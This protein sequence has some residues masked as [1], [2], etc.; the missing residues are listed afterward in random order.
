MIIRN[1]LLTNGS[2]SMANMTFVSIQDGAVIAKGKIVNMT[3]PNTASQQATRGIFTFLVAQ[4]RAM[5]G[6]LNLIN[7]PSSARR[8]PFNQFMANNIGNLKEQLGDGSDNELNRAVLTLK[9]QLGDSEDL[10]NVVVTP[11]ATTQPVFVNGVVDVSVEWEYDSFNPNVLGTDG[12][13]VILYN[14]EGEYYS[15]EDGVATMSQ[16]SAFVTIRRPAKGW[17]FYYFIWQRG[18]D[19]VYSPS[20]GLWA[21]PA[22]G[23]V[24]FVQ[25]AVI[26]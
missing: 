8:S 12:L 10:T 18:T 1:P 14:Q 21:V 9:E 25:T 16:E 24:L 7:T 15:K 6:I 22:V 17:N 3:N 11:S 26:T 5:K 13:D 19:A 23:N 2:G 20:Y 4:F